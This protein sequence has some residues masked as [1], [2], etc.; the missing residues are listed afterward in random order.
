ML[1]FRRPLRDLAQSPITEKPLD[2]IVRHQPGTLLDGHRLLNN[3]LHGFTAEEFDDGGVFHRSETL[4]KKPGPSIGHIARG[5][6][7][8]RH[9]RQDESNRLR[10]SKSL[11]VSPVPFDE[12]EGRF[13]CGLPHPC[14]PGPVGDPS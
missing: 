5:F 2:R 13:K 3:R 7:H 10:F 14:A 11:T 1:N 4:I 6:K 12:G 8:H 9:F